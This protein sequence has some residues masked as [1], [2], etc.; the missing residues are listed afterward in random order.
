MRVP[1][2]LNI[3]IK[4]KAKMVSAISALKMAWKSS[5]RKVGSSDWGIETTE[6]LE[7]TWVTPI[8]IPTM[9]M[10]IML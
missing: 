1:M 5:F 8:G 2:V 4:T 10:M 9:V 7:G 6:K 3:S